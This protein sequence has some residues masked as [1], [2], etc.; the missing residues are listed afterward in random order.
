MAA[1]FYNVHRGKDDRAKTAHD[2]LPDA[3]VDPG[4]AERERKAKQKEI[5]IALMLA[6]P[7][8]LE[9]V[10]QWARARAN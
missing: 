2:F 7:I 5:E 9:D 10:P 3:K 6:R 4:A 8:K 1:M